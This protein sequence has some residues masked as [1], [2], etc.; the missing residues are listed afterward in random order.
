LRTLEFDGYI[1]SSQKEGGTVYQFT[2]P[3]LRLWWQQY[4]F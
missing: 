3:V 2:S 1:F 4:V